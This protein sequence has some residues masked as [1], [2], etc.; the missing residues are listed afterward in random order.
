MGGRIRQRNHVPQG[1]SLG[2]HLCRV[3]PCCAC[4][5]WLHCFAAPWSS[6]PSYREDC[7]GLIGTLLHAAVSRSYNVHARR[8]EMAR[9]LQ[10]VRTKP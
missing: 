5:A 1:P 2:T 8:T 3:L 9:R 4:M 10:P 6:Q 7:R